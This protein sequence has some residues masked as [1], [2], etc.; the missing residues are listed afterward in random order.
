MIRK[1]IF[2]ILGGIFFLTTN[3]FANENVVS[4]VTF[5]VGFPNST[6]GQLVTGIKFSFCKTADCA[7]EQTVVYTSKNQ[8][9]DTHFFDFPENIPAKAA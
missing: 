5:S 3:V 6:S 4:S 9:V 2:A 7:N 1:I 8:M